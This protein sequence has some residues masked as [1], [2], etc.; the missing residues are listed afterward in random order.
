MTFGSSASLDPSTTS[1]KCLSIGDV[2]SLVAKQLNVDIEFITSEA[3]F[4]NDLGAD[5][6]DALS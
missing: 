4:T 1:N 3:H 6:I 5:L 2:R